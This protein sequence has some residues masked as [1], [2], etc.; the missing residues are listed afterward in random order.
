MPKAEQKKYN[1]KNKYYHK[2][3]NS[4]KEEPMESIRLIPLGGLNEIGKN[5]TVYECKGDMFIVDCG[6]TFP[7]SEMFGVDLVI[8]DFSY[9]VENKDK[10]KGIIITHG[11]ED[12]I[13]ALPYLLKEVN[14]PVYAT[15]LTK[16]LIENKLSEHQLKSPAEITVIRPG[17][18]IQMGCMT[19][20]PIH[21]NHSIPDAVGLA[22]ESP[23][24]VVIT[25]MGFL[26][27]EILP[28]QVASLFTT[29][30]TLI[31]ISRTGFIISF[32]FFSA[33]GGQIVIQN[34]FQS[35]GK[36]KVSIF[37][38]LTRQL[39]FLIPTLLILPALFGLKG[40]WW[41]LAVSDLLAFIV[42]IITLVVL[43]KRENRHF[44]MINNK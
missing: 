8:P 30:A 38:S 39:L 33:V 20:V 7:D 29:D 4:I 14:L 15:R 12:H 43:L 32:V 19:V 13:G 27:A 1:R 2:K 28:Q 9:V 41:S 22:I 24:G 25:T 23:A 5:M 3:Q 21:V 36:P 34:F 37:L 6:N 18:R 26:V 40:V 11:H 44:S 10:I 35:I 17:D 42:G 16:G 31:G